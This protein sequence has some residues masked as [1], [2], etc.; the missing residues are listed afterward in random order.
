MPQVA[1]WE[2]DDP[3]GS[4]T[5][6][7]SVDGD[8]SQ[9]GTFRNGAGTNGSG[10]G[11]F[12]GQNDVV[13]VPYD[14]VF[15]LDEGS[16]VVTF[17]QTAAST[18]NVPFGG[19][20][21]MTLFSRDSSNFDNGGH[22]TIF[23]LRNG[24]VG[25]RHQTD[26]ENFNFRGGEITLNQ[27][28]TVIYS[29]S[30]T[31]SQL[32]VDGTVVDTGT[33]ALTLAGDPQ[34]LTIGASQAQSGNGTANNL[35]GFFEG[36]IN[37]VAIFDEVVDP[38]VMACFV[39]G[40][41]ILTDTGERPVEDLAVGDLVQTLD[42]GLC[43]IEWIGQREVP[44]IGRMA[45]IRFEARAIGNAEP[46]MVSPQHRMLLRHW[47]SELLFGEPEV[48]VKAKDLVNDSTVRQIP[49][50]RGVRYFHIALGQHEVI[51]A[52]GVPTES[53]AHG[54]EALKALDAEMRAEY[55]TLF[56]EAAEGTKR[57]PC[58]A[59]LTSREYRAYRRLTAH[60]LASQPMRH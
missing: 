36:E 30:P 47:R 21:A 58:R 33:E 32:I 8:G 45:P 50:A 27:Q 22:L 54:P 19:N 59:P 7:D 29:W 43:P 38:E 2:F 60:E 46:L 13:E 25:V 48:L 20:P 12:D 35:K 18:G 42:R 52:N 40:T 3:F 10:S 55:L 51:F 44:G 16:V 17:T 53:F 57:D 4:P 11:T 23:I 56:P 24:T 34:P 37:G 39:S 9:D 41:M 26:S 1:F 6:D 15:D 49:R 28:S 31:G 5:A 14:P